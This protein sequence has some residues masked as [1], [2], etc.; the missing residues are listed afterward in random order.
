[1]FRVLFVSRAHFLAFCSNSNGVVGQIYWKLE[2]KERIR[3]N[4]LTDSPLLVE[5]A[6]ELLARQL[7][8][9]GWS[10]IGSQQ[11]SIEA[12]C[13]GALALVGLNPQASERAL[14]CF[15]KHQLQ[16]GGWPAFVPDREPSWTTSL[17][18]ITFSILADTS[19]ARERAVEWALT[20]KGKEGH[21]F[22]RYKFHVDKAVQFRPEFYGWP[23]ME[24]TCS[25][26][27]STG[28]M[29]V[30]IKQYVFCKPLAEASARLRLAARMLLD[31]SCPGGGWNA[32]NSVMYGVPLAAH[33][34]STAIAL[35][36]LQAEPDHPVIR[37]GMDWLEK[38][39]LA[40]QGMASLSWTVLCLA[41]SGREIAVV[42]AKIAE[43]LHDAS[44]LPSNTAT[45][46]L[47][48]LALRCQEM[49]HPF[50][51]AV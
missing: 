17:A 18:L 8:S 7:K 1:L 33:V 12:T 40:E 3:E 26:V 22:W 45:L 25:W 37:A 4:M 11:P 38:Q 29:M 24:G 6:S 42:Q 9:G 41:A 50:I 36:G 35:L 10:Y 44:A 15:S 32:G 30:G 19:A 48:L 14:L 43:Q 20:N 46:A 16:S 23:W 5:Q 31:R 34:E 21:W 47:G 2:R 13:L 27:I 39:A 49:I 28:L 51:V